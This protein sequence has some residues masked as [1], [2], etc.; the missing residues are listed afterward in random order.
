M[1]K[2]NQCIELS[3]KH[4]L[5]V[6]PDLQWEVQCGKWELRWEVWLKSKEQLW[7]NFKT[8]INGTGYHITTNY[9]IH[10]SKSMNQTE[11]WNIIVLA[12]VLS[13]PHLEETGLSV[14]MHHLAMSY[15]VQ[16]LQRIISGL[17]HYFE[18][19]PKTFAKPFG[20]GDEKNHS[21]PPPTSS[22]FSIIL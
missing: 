5:R 10:V 4:F 13:K 22:F 17:C 6:S 1:I 3:N 20:E 7:G 8:L 11:F 14:M 9:F 2:Y 16:S 19:S 15:L 18:G 12:S 21:I